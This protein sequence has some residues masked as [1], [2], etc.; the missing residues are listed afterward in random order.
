MPSKVAELMQTIIGLKEVQVREQ[1]Q[2]LAEQMAP[3]QQA[4]VQSNVLGAR[5]NILQG[6]TDPNAVAPYVDQFAQGTGL[7]PNAMGAVIHGTAPSP[8][9]VVGGAM[10]A[11]N[12]GGQFNEQAAAHGLTGQSVGDLSK[13]AFFKTIFGSAQEYLGQMPAD[14]RQQFI[15]GVVQR[16]GTGQ[17]LTEA[18]I[19]QAV[20]HLT[21]EERL[22][23]LKVGKGLA[24]SASEDAQIKLGYTNARIQDRQVTSQSA[25]QQL[26]A[27]VRMAEVNA[28]LT[29]A[30][31]DEVSNIL[32]KR[33]EL[34]QKLLTNSATLTDEGV[35]STNAQL[36]GYNEM[37]RKMAPEI[38]GP[39]GTAPLIDIPQNKTLGTTGVGQA[40][41]Q[42]V[43]AKR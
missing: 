38:F 30:K 24:P 33:D 10:S 2:Q 26:D 27:M 31:K 4:L 20:M 6:M 3:F 25:A 29:G 19:D 39:K 37:L 23:A 17:S 28:R 16:A 9:T 22:Q 32:I 14:Q 12:A 8:S 15:S 34:Q 43:K 11:G 7:D 18:A 21:P 13:D 35:Q 41:Y 42:S 5:Q 40:I 36:N 1:A